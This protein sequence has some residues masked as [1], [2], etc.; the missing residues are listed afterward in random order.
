M[1][2]YVLSVSLGFV[3]S[4]ALA[5]DS[6]DAKARAALAAYAPNARIEKIAPAPVH[7][8]FEVVVGGQVYYVSDD[9]KYLVTGTVFDIAARRDLTEARRGTLR[10]GA[11]TAFG[12]DQRIIFAAQQPKHTVTVF[13]DLDCSFCRRLHS[14]IAEYNKRGISV[15]YLFFPRT[16]PRTESAAKAVSVWC[17]A[18]RKAT[19]TL[20]KAGKPVPSKTCAA[21]VAAEFAL[22]QRVGV[23][24]TPAIFA[25]DGSQIGGYV[26]PDEMLAKLDALKN[27]V[28]ARPS[29]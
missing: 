15:E 21:P 27:H 1:S 6:G 22:G 4:S 20:A 11:L 29:K 19:F 13:T 7:G 28:A 16:G 8:L 24:G 26:S 5:A 12:D 23:T 17:A 18:D 2:K 3:F 25:E 9:G 14:Q 10:K